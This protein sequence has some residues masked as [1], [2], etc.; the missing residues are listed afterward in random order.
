MLNRSVPIIAIQLNALKVDNN[1]ILNFTKVLD[2][3]EVPEDEEQL[4][5]E[6][7]SRPYW[8]KKA[9]PKSIELMDKIT[10]VSVDKYPN[11]RI[12]YNKHHI[13]V[14][15]ERRNFMWFYP[16]KSPFCRFKI[17][18]DR[19]EV[20]ELSVNLEQLGIS[21]SVRKEDEIAISI[22]LTEYKKHKE[23]VEAIVVKSIQLYS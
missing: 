16:R 19:E 23:L 6:E 10:Q 3:Y 22:N 20:E 18:L 8:E 5:G 7:V 11:T 13:A 14:G 17:K 9:D 4:A 12:T 21:F 1:I 2:L 15:T